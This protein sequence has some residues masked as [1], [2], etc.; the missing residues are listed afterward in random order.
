MKRYSFREIIKAI[1]PEE[2][3]EIIFY[4][5]YKEEE[6][7][8]EII[9]KGQKFWVEAVLARKREKRG[10]QIVE[11]YACQIEDMIVWLE[12]TETGQAKINIKDQTI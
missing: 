5:G 10:G 11:I 2:P 6:T 4:S 9:I 7:P 8:R 3:I 1:E 12:K